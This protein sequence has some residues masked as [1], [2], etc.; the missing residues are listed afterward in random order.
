MIGFDLS[1]R[2]TAVSLSSKYNN[3]RPPALPVRTA[4]SLF[5]DGWMQRRQSTIWSATVSSNVVV[6]LVVVGVFH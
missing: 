2:D 6:N 3:P 5:F 1:L 4:M